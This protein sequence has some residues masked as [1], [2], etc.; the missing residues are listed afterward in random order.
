[1]STVELFTDILKPTGTNTNLS[2]YSVVIPSTSVPTVNNILKATSA[3]NAQWLSGANALKTAGADVDV[4][5]SSAPT[6]GQV[7]LT[8]T[9]TTAVWST[10]ANDEPKNPVRVTTTTS[11]ILASDFENGDTV[12]GVVLSTGD[13]I[14]IKDQDTPTENGVYTVNVSGAP[15]RAPDFQ[16]G[17][18]ISSF[19]FFTTEGTVNTNVAFICA[20]DS[21]NDVVGTDNLTF[22]VYASAG[23]VVVVNNIISITRAINAGIPRIII[24]PGTY[25]I[26]TQLL[27]FSNVTI[28]GSG[29]GTTIFRATVASI[30]LISMSSRSNITIKGITFDMNSVD[31][32]AVFG[33]TLSD[34]ILTDCNFLN[35]SGSDTTVSILNGTNLLIES[36]FFDQVAGARDVHFSGSS[37]GIISKCI[38]NNR[39]SGDNFRI[40]GG[41]NSHGI[42]TENL[43]LNNTGAG[44]LI[45]GITIVSN[46]IF[47]SIT[48][49]P[50]ATLTANGEGTIIAN[51]TFN[52]CDEI[53]ITSPVIITGNHITNSTVNGITFT[54]S[55]ANNSVVS[56]NRISGS[57]I[58]D[59]SINVNINFMTIAKNSFEGRTSFA[60]PFI[61]Q[62]IAND[63]LQVFNNIAT[64]TVTT[65]AGSQNAQGDGSVYVI[66]TSGG[67]LNTIS[68]QPLPK[69]AAGHRCSFIAVD[70][71]GSRPLRVTPTLTVG[72]SGT[73]YTSVEMNAN[74]ESCSFIWTGFAWR[75]LSVGNGTLIP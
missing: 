56:S 39:T 9:S 58:N 47:D 24:A 11:G 14:L 45:N 13:R 7:L 16:T 1:M 65:V 40:D 29:R 17:A 57:T 31:S 59:I 63:F 54:G 66:T 55:A 23:N 73:T 44:L 6:S 32:T 2:L 41:A 3:T 68:L 67:A 35:S 42:L 60:T 74:N 4:S 61:S 10:V 70:A 12:D 64:Y 27:P 51:N 30:N 22:N 37:T 46:C 38:F 19:F 52:N 28:E 72:T 18:S 53:S 26:A 5:A 20:N 75:I 21:P 71:N 69:G 50:I 62:S 25:D 8:T 36:C 43:F 48:S 34:F 49:N 15:T 33:S